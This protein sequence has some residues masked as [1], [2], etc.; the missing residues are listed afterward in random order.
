MNIYAGNPSREVTEEELQQ[1]FEAFGQ[2]LLF[3]RLPNFKIGDQGF[4]L[5]CFH[6]KLEQQAGSPGK[7]LH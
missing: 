2:K 5:K 1:E 7:S 6:S 3:R 4:Q